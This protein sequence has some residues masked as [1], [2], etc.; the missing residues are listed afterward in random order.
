L[1]EGLRENEIEIVSTDHAPHKP[2]E[3]ALDFS[4][5][6]AGISSADLVLP[7]LTTLV[8]RGELEF[9]DVVRLCLKNPV[10]VHRLHNETELRAGG[11]ADLVFFDPR[12]VWTVR[13]ADFLSKACRSPYVGMELTGRVAATLVAGKTAYLDGE[14][15]L[16]SVF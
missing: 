2:G 5:V 1:L 10:K 13:E 12:A 11:A 7:L 14:G 3:K 6:P 8:A 9:K 16:G 4:R 15:P